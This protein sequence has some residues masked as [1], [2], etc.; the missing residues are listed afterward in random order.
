MKIEHC[1]K[2][3]SL[4]SASVCLI[5]LA[6]NVA[7]A[8]VTIDA[9]TVAAQSINASSSVLAQSQN[10]ESFYREGVVKLDK[11]D[12]RGAVSDFTKA[13]QLKPNYADAYYDRGRAN[14]FLQEYRISVA[15]GVIDYF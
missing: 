15:W 4:K 14:F 9:L 7:V 6:T 3:F 10:A 1:Q 5:M 2:L 12:Y 8:F 11:K 13:I